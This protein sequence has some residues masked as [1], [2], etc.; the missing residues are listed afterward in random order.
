MDVLFQGRKVEPNEYLDI[1]DMTP[2]SIRVSPRK[3]EVDREE[4]FEID[5]AL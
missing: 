4:N 5:R 1:Y 3:V 2:V